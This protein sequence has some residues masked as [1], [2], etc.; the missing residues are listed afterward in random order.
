MKRRT[1]LIG[2]ASL[3]VGLGGL[4]WRGAT[5]SMTAYEA[6]Q[7]DMRAEP[8]PKAGMVDLARIASLAPSGHNTQPWLLRFAENRIDVLPDFSRRTPVVDPDDHHLFVS[9]GAAAE[10]LSVGGPA[11]GRPGAATAQPDGSLRYD[12]V[13]SNGLRR[14]SALVA[15]LRR[16]SVRAEY[17]GRS[18]PALEIDAL[19]RKAAL[20]G[21]RVILIADRP[22]LD[23]LRDLA[24]DGVRTQFGDP[25]FIDE[26]RAWIRFN[27]REALA[28]GDGLF[29]AATGVPVAPDLVGRLLFGLWATVEGETDRLLRQMN[30]TPLVAVFF[31]ED[32]APRG[33]AQVGRSL[34]RFTIA[35]TQRGLKTSHVNQAAEVAALRPALAALAGEPGLRP[36]IVL[37]LGYGPEMPYSPR[38]PVA[39]ILA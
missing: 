30:S 11:F 3:G 5:G 38:R 26:L 8:S 39:R 2:G 17:D 35:A 18:P 31:A 9:L 16:Q 25:A 23:A 19:L 28:R 32:P 10:T 37:R 24:A 34:T 33:W 6:A 1:L 21:V 29:A 27:P 4:A 13:R 20:P 22:R 36:D 15:I 12:F 7:S 14:D